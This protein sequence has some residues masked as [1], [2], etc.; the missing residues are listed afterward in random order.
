MKSIKKLVLEGFMLLASVVVLAGCKNDSVPEVTPAKLVSITVTP[1]TRTVYS[2]GESFD[3]TVVLT[4]TY[5]DGEERTVEGT[6]TSETSSLTQTAGIDKKVT[7]SYTEGVIQ[8]LL[9]LL[10][11]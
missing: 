9:P 10:W 8:K 7:V 4:A 3:N 2:V 5:D 6:I 11:M 1:P